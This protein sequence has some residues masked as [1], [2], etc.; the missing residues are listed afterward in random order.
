MIRTNL[1][2]RPFYNEG[3]VRL[4][5]GAVA[6]LV[7]LATAWNGARLLHDSRSDTALKAQAAADE[8]RAAELRRE[9]ATL[10]AGVDAASLAAAAAEAGI[11]NG[12]IDRRTFSWTELFNRFEATLPESVRLSAVQP[13]VEDDRRVTLTLTASARSVADIDEFL[14]NLEDTGLFADM[15]SREE[16]VTDQ[17]LVDAAIEGVYMPA[18]RERVT[19][20]AA[21]A[22]R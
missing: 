1:A 20:P 7:V 3:R 17:G 14:E 15:L 9:A 18:P 5:L 11:A 6:L 2:T 12:L 22:G 16:R 21:G 19:P 10:R 8:A 13:R 4:W